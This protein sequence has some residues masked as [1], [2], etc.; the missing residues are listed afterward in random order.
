[1][2]YGKY[3]LVIA[4]LVLSASGTCATVELDNSYLGEVNDY[5]F[6]VPALEDEGYTVLVYGRE[7]AREGQN[8]YLGFLFYAVHNARVEETSSLCYDNLILLENE[9]GVAYEPDSVHIVEDAGVYEWSLKYVKYKYVGDF[10]GRCTL[11]VKLGNGE[12]A[13]LDMGPAECDFYRMGT[14]TARDGVAVHVA[15]NDASPVLRELHSGD[16]FY[17]TGR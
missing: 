7:V 13:R 3:V 15:P 1:M 5:F 8:V 16:T 9:A 17:Y 10:A 14:V 12:T 6:T 2:S 11:L 4:A